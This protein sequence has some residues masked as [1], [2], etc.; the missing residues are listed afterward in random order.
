MER[1]ASHSFID[2]VFE[3]PHARLA[4]GEAARAV[5]VQPSVLEGANVDR[6][7]ARAEAVQD[8]ASTVTFQT[9][10]AVLLP[11]FPIRDS[12]EGAELGEL[13]QSVHQLHDRGIADT[14]AAVDVE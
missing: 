14:L 9:H 1:R 4:V 2:S 6:V 10:S 7:V 5:A 13:R 11:E 8:A 3:G 12:V